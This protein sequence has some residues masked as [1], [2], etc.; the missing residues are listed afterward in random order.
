RTRALRFGEHGI[1]AATHSIDRVSLAFI[2]QEIHLHLAVVRREDELSSHARVE[3]AMMLVE[4]AQRGDVV[5]QRVIIQHA[6]AENPDPA[7]DS[8]RAAKPISAA[9]MYAAN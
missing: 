3:K 8:H 1:T 2:D 6:M 4:P 5:V 7:L 9:P